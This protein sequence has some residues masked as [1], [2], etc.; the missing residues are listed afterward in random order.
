MW[1]QDCDISRGWDTL[2]NAYS[3]VLHTRI[4]ARE[5]GVGAIAEN[6]PAMCIGPIG[7]INACNPRQAALDAYD[8][9]SLH[10]DGHAREAASIIAAAVA[11]AMNPTA[12]VQRIVD[13]SIACLP[14]RKDSRMY[15]PMVKALELADKA[16]DTEE[17]TALFYDQL[18][19]KWENRVT[20]YNETD[21]KS[22]SIE[23]LE[24]IPCAVAMF[25]KEQGDYRRSVI[26]S[27]NFGRD[28]DTVACMTGYI[29][30]AFNGVD[31]IPEKWIATTNEANPD[32]NIPELAQQL[33]QTL[34][35]ENERTAQR[36]EIIKAMQ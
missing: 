17:L 11:E 10:H 26:A 23:P 21:R 4:P 15:A 33:T 34:M 2:K 27:A 5:L 32:P 20:Y 31:A 16:R 18:K 22:I 25:Y 35:T 3:K 30:G 1:L 6:S 8:V 36:C 29:A 28:C 14:G 7:V 12:T 19:V 9:V 24:S 13:A